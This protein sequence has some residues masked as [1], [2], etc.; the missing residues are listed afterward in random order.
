LV[1]TGLFET[2]LTLAVVFAILASSGF[3][4]FITVIVQ[5]H[6]ENKYSVSSRESVEREM[7]I[8]LAHDRILSLGMKYIQRGYITRDEYENINQ[9]LYEPYSKLGGNG[10]AK[11]IME[12]L[13]KLPIRACLI[14]E[15]RKDL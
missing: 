14:T 5:K 6:L 15:K 4:A 3:W 2:D 10:S 8:G 13:N 7:L 11:K 1:N 9:Y 12:E